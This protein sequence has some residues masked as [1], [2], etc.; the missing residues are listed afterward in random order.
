[1]NTSR[2]ARI[3]AL[4][5]STAVTFVIVSALAGYGYPP[6]DAGVTIAHAADATVLR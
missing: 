5:A 6:A 3:A 4:L 1:M 2:T